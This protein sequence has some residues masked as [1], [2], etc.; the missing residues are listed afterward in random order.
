MKIRH[1]G[2]LGTVL[3][4][5]FLAVLSV[6]AQ[7]EDQAELALKAAIKTEVVDGDLRSAIEQYKKIAALP[8]AGR[9]TVATA[10][11]RTGQC[12]E[13]L[14][15]SDTEESRKAYERIV[16]EYADQTEAVTV[17]R[18]KLDNILRAAS[19]A[20]K[21]EAGP[22]IR[23]IPTP[24]DWEGPGVV[25]PDGKYLADIDGN[26]GD[27]CLGELD[28][29]KTRRLTN[30]GNEYSQYAYSP[31]WAPDSTRLAFIWVDADGLEELRVMGLDGSEPR[32]LVGANNERRCR[33]L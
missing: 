6:E 22:T 15:E 4:A 3:L 27:L 31:T 1:I 24:D 28:T 9:A 14:G 21:K 19:L 12:Y 2:L 5:V 30:E 13:K 7:K 8:R 23:Q 16:R 26:T 33:E 11:L 10:L 25:S 20:K 32:T 18:E 17:A 29:G